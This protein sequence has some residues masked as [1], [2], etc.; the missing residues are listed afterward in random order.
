MAILI[1]RET[2]VAVQGITGREGKYHTEVMLKYGTSLKAGVS[3]GK[4]G[5]KVHEIP[6]YD[7]L[8]EG[9]RY[10]GVEASIVMV[11]PPFAADALYEGAEAG[12]K[13]IVCITEGIPLHDTMKALKRIEFFY[14]HTRI[15]GPNS[16][17]IISPGQALLGIMPGNIFSPGNVGIISRS[18]TLTYQIA[19]ELTRAGIGQST[20]VGV[21]GDPLIG[22]RFLDLLKLFKEDPQTKALCLI[23]EI[24]GKDEEEAA[25]YIKENFPKPVVAYV[26]GQTAPPGKK[27]GHAGAIASGEEGTALSKST[28]LKEAGAYTLEVPYQVAQVFKE[29]LIN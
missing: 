23:G 2:K 26:A 3:P 12:L 29:V 5:Q 1:H 8:E 9:V 18:G 28:A 7:T 20:V 22:T 25:E 6:V 17:G 10:G 14:P 15:I 11:P 13:L 16:P 24:G 21:G 27:M 4:G 19:Y